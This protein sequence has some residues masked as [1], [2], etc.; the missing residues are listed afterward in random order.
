[1]IAAD[2]VA[3]VDRLAAF[4]LS[5]HD[6]GGMSVALIVD[7]S[8]SWTKTYGWADAN[9]HPDA[10]TVYRAA[11]VTKP[12]TGLM[13]LQLAERGALRLSDPLTLY[14][15][16]FSRVPAANDRTVVTLVQLATMT[17]GMPSEVSV[18]GDARTA[19]PSR[20]EQAVIAA[21]PAITPFAEPGT[22][23]LYS[24]L[25]YGLLGLAC[26][27]A[28]R[29]AYDEYVRD[30]I[31]RPLGMA[32]SGFGPTLGPLPT[33]A[34]GYDLSDGAVETEPAEREH[35]GRGY[36]LPAG[37]LYATLDD[38]C[39]F[40]SFC[41]GTEAPGVIAPGAWSG[42]LDAVVAADRD[43]NFGEGVGFAAIR[44]LTGAV[45][46]PGHFGIVS[47]YKC[48]IVYAPQDRVGMVVC[49]NLTRTG[50]TTDLA[51]SMLALLPRLAS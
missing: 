1:M 36:G 8:V 38:L 13:L 15:P 28:A 25:S 17:A 9:R 44:D 16:E 11:S 32:A 41:L 26:A 10:S 45:A 34:R 24:N 33:L 20:F 5:T 31:L 48:G 12:F 27:R 21:L 42:A 43:L 2:V 46:A 7:G 19:P 3:D 23:F 39:R 37:G 51:R 22:R 40:V 29:R 50:D 49:A 47:G 6:V 14:V 4:E 18:E 30:E 35:R